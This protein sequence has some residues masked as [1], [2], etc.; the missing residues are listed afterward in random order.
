MPKP[1]QFCDENGYDIV[2]IQM[3]RVYMDSY[4]TSSDNESSIEEYYEMDY[5]PN[6]SRMSEMQERWLVSL[7]KN[8][9]ERQIGNVLPTIVSWPTKS[10]ESISN[11]HAIIPKFQIQLVVYKIP[12]YFY[13]YKDDK[14]NLTSC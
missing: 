2:P 4:D 1:T 7:Q 9:E 14:G 13:E 3:L 11:N 5:N 6:S 12:L 8:A 10:V